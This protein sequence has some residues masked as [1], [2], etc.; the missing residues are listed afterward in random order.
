ML[1][2]VLGCAGAWPFPLCILLISR[3][4]IRRFWPQSCFRVRP[5]VFPIPY[6]DQRLG[7]ANVKCSEAM[8]K[9]TAARK[10]RLCIERITRVGCMSTRAIIKALARNGIFLTATKK[11]THNANKWARPQRR[12][13]ERSNRRYKVIAIR[14][15]NAV[16]TKIIDSFFCEQFRFAFR[17]LITRECISLGR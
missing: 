9:G 4:A 11:H 14:S 1:V 12:Q 8:H 3:F 15:V 6:G 5:E 2:G 16:P 13:D 7:T 17:C 10:L